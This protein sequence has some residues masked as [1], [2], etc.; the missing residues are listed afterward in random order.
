MAEI[1]AF[2]SGRM[3]S[4]NGQ[5][6]AWKQLDPSGRVAMVDLDRLIEN[7]FDVDFNGP[8]DRDYLRMVPDRQNA[9]VMQA[10]DR[11]DGRMPD[12]RE[13]MEVRAEL[14][15]AAERVPSAG[16]PKRMGA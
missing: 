7:I 9:H 5:R 10:Y 2:N 12:Y 4:V 3:Y 13:M 16:G 6:I 8:L 1:K 11:H 15:A 14:R